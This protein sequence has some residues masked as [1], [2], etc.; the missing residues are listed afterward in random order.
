MHHKPVFCQHE[1]SVSRFTLNELITLKYQL[2]GAGHRL[3]LF[4]CPDVSCLLIQHTIVVV[5]V[6]STP[7]LLC[8]TN[9]CSDI[10]K[11]SLCQNLG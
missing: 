7:N 5:L 10:Y 3:C 4:S 1:M 11:L 6:G 8:L 9:L 2:K